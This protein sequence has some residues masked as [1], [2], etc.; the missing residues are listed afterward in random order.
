MIPEEKQTFTFHGNASWCW[1]APRTVSHL[2]ACGKSPVPDRLSRS[3]T[4]RDAPRGGLREPVGQSAS[5]CLYRASN[6]EA[7]P[8]A[9]PLSVLISKPNRP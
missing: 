2:F 1:G 5:V 9:Q 8:R 6:I 7:V 4:G 3:R